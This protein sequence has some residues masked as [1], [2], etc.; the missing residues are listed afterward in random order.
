MPDIYLLQGNCHCGRIIF[1]FSSRISPE[2]FT[3]RACDCSFCQR[4]GA[5]YIS[6]PNG[7]LVLDV[8]EAGAL[9]EYQF[10]HK[11]AKFLFCRHCGVFVAV[12]FKTQDRIFGSVNSRC[13][14]GDIRFRDAQI[15]SPQALG[16]EQKKE[17]WGKVMIPDVQLR[18]SV[19]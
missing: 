8:K 1:N 14:G 11:L 16:A 10:G 7:S 13:I 12:L 19:S 3:P 2:K 6:D 17:R 9:G 15:I 18:A 5:L 4:H